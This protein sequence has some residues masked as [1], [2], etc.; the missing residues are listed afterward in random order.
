MQREGVKQGK[1]VGEIDPTAPPTRPCS[2]LFY[3]HS[4]P[5]PRSSLLHHPQPH[6]LLLTQRRAPGTTAAPL[7]TG[8]EWEE[9]ENEGERQ[10][11]AA[12]LLERVRDEL[13]QGGE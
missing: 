2:P 9:R 5:S 13:G 3:L 10:A 12:P 1:N 7:S 6:G 11:V 4:P 8:T